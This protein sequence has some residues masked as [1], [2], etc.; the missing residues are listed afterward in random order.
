MYQQTK[1][2]GE[3]IKIA[4]RHA[5]HMV[6]Q[7]A[8]M[9]GQQG[10][11]ESDDRV[12]QAQL[13]EEQQKWSKAINAYLDITEDVQPDQNLLERYWVRAANL[14]MDYDKPKMKQV[15]KVVCKRLIDIKR[16]EAAAILFENIG[17]YQQT[18]KC[19]IMGK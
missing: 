2:I 9:R 15:L 7:L 14:A 13:W 5:P 10:G 11:M 18:V 12:E 17:M 3:A 19:Y 16:Y 8:D 6:G 4:K 1:Q